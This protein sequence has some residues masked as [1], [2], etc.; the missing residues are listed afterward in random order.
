MA[1]GKRPDRPRESEFKKFLK[2]RA[3]IYLAV[4][5]IVVVFVVPELT[6][7][8]LQ[9]MLPKDLTEEEGQVLDVLMNYRGPDK[10][11]FRLI[12]ALSEKIEDEYPD[13]RIYDNKKTSLDVRILEAESGVHQVLLNFKSYKGELD[14][15]WD[16]DT[17]TQEISGNDSGS[18]YLVDY[19]DFYD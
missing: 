10:E 5:A 6:K 3:P 17:S 9:G 14:Y 15:S 11:G 19:V 1:K 18:K 16:V 12:D 7:G 13:E 4:A 8:D 2:K